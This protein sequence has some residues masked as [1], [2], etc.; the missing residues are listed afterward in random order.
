MSR[1]AVRAGRSTALIAA[2]VV[3]AALLA[4][5]IIGAIPTVSGYFLDY[6]NGRADLM[7]GHVPQIP[8]HGEVP[9]EPDD[10]NY[11]GVLISSTEA[12]TGPRML[13]A[14][15]AV[16]GILVVI[17]GSLLAV[18]L[19]VRMLRGHSFTRLFSWGLGALGA[20][21]MIAAAV[22]PQLNALAVDIAVQELGYR[23]YDPAVDVTMTADGVESVILSLW[24]LEWILDRV[25]LTGFLLGVIIALLGLLVADGTRLQRD[26]E[27]LV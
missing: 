14:I 13:Q 4:A 16:L 2:L 15:A 1:T 23:I 22:A 26:T 8:V 11:S 20:L 24:D 21:V 10:A 5:A 9:A 18:L 6:W 19:A 12:L 27:G 17:T 7:T 3:G 25:D